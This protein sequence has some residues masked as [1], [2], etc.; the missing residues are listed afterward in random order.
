MIVEV[1]RKRGE[2]V[3]KTRDRAASK[4]FLFEIYQ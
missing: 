3:K 1:E 4:S 2:E